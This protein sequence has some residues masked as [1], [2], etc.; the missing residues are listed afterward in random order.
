[1]AFRLALLEGQPRYIG[2]LKLAAEKAGWGSK[3]PAGHAR[4]VALHKSF[5]TYV[6]EVAEISLQGDR[7]FKVERVVCAVD[8]GIAVNPDVVRAQIVIT[9]Y[10]IHYTKLYE[11]RS[12]W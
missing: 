2:V 10:S 5:N 4:G 1:M 8:C 11:I 12:T 7:Q 6:A 3:L 9:S